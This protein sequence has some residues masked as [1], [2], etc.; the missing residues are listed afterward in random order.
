MSLGAPS[1]WSEAS[2]SSSL[3]RPRLDAVVWNGKDFGLWKMRMEGLFMAHD[4][5]IA[6][7]TDVAEQAMAAAK[8]LP[9][10]NDCCR[11]RV[12]AHP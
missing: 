12:N 8:A 6:V 5:L 11:K 1:Q 2:R 7:E 4:L 9:M 10:P 3:H